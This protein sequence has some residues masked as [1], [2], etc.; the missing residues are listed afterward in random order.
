MQKCNEH[1]NFVLYLDV[2]FVLFCM[3]NSLAGLGTIMP[4]VY[5]VDR[6]KEAGIPEVKGAF[7]LSTAGI[8]N[9]ISRFVFGWSLF[10]RC[11]KY[12]RTN[13]FASYINLWQ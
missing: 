4:Y 1:F 11:F 5:L 2:A 10:L 12:L 13:I 6:T 7:L 3:T 9:T 8:A